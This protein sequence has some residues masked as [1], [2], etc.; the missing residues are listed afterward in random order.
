MKECSRDCLCKLLSILTTCMSRER[1]LNGVSGECVCV[2]GVGG[3]EQERLKQLVCV[4][5]LQGEK[6][7]RV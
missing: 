3:G 6:V 5:L 2:G 7:P 1:Y 4:Q